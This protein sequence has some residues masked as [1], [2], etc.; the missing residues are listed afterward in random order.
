MTT[1]S[2]LIT[3]IRTDLIRSDIDTVIGQ[4]I[5]DAIKKYQGHRFHFNETRDCVLTLVDGTYRYTSSSSYTPSTPTIADFFE[6]DAVIIIE[7]SQNYGPLDKEDP[8]VIER[9]ASDSSAASGRPYCYARYADG[10]WFYPKPDSTSRTA[11]LMGHYRLA[12]PASDG[13]ADNKW[14]TDPAAFQLIRYSAQTIIYGPGRYKDVQKAAMA[15]HWEAYWLNELFAR[16]SKKSGTNRI[17]GGM[18]L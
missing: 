3:Q 5:D 7:N 9:L 2:A 1:K 13:E 12:G 6:L 8:A 16:N 17:R 10:I 18:P 4:A 11:R 15:A 14:M